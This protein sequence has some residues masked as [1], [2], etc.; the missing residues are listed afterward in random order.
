M[1]RVR[2]LIDFKNDGLGRGFTLGERYV[3]AREVKLEGLGQAFLADDTDAA[4]Q[5]VAVVHRAAW[6]GDP[7]RRARFEE[8][9]RV[10]QSIEH[11]NVA[12]FLDFGIAD[13]V[14]YTILERLDGERLA[15]RLTRKRAIPVEDVVP[16]ISQ[17][18][19][20]L[21]HL[22][23]RGIIARNISPANL[24]LYT[25]GVHANVMRLMGAGLAELL[26]NDEEPDESELVTNPAFA[27]PEQL[28][29]GTATPASDVY[30]AGRLME[31]MLRGSL[32]APS[33]PLSQRGQSGVSTLPPSARIPTSL[34]D[35]MSRATALEPALRPPDGAALVEGL[36]DAVPS[37]SM[38]RL[39][40]VTN[41]HRAMRSRSSMSRGVVADVVSGV[42][43]DDGDDAAAAPSHRSPS[44]SQ[45]SLALADTPPTKSSRAALAIGLLAFAAAGAAVWLWMQP[46]PDA[47][48]DGS[49][50]KAADLEVAAP[51]G[52]RAAAPTPD[53][54]ARDDASAAVPASA[55]GSVRVLSDPPGTLKIDGVSV[56]PSP[57]AGEL[58]AGR[59][60]VEV[61][62]SDGTRWSETIEVGAGVNE[63]WK[64]RRA[65][66]PASESSEAPP[67]ARDKSRKRRRGKTAPP[68]PS[69]D[70]A[71]APA[72]K[73]PAA[74]PPPPARNDPFLP[75]SKKRAPTRDTDLLPGQSPQ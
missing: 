71:A 70:P 66:T 49:E 14:V 63:T 31:T 36:I 72:S 21:E 34:L 25:D 75:R 20:A 38:L 54:S 6:V 7:Q 62:A 26:L 43:D 5:V 11:A 1:A 19:K 39:R 27:A 55:L 60:T 58:S 42:D 30:S 67:A 16:I 45:A 53:A 40:R 50:T 10:L 69:A 12:T 2:S 46:S 28:Q 48:G 57:Y 32:G 65:D 4:R 44:A 13:G 17:L 61:E 59:H 15:D 22:H 33:T 68:T 74:T 24:L 18:L 52:T 3:L 64:L 73:P 9:A 56:G 47:A 8:R 29:G 51:P 37:V 23:A 41:S 35:F